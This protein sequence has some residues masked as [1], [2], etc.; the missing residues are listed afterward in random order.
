M[1]TNALTLIMLITSALFA[2]QPEFLECS[3]PACSKEKLRYYEAH[4][5]NN[6]TKDV[7][8][9]IADSIYFRFEVS[10]NGAVSINQQY[11]FA[12]ARNLHHARLRL[13]VLAR[14]LKPTEAGNHY[15]WVLKISIPEKAHR[16]KPHNE[17][18]NLPPVEACSR[19]NKLAREACF[20]YVLDEIIAKIHSEETYDDSATFIFY[21]K[22]ARVDAVEVL[23]RPKE[24]AFTDRATFIID[25][26]ITQVGPN[27]NGWRAD[28]LKLSF[29]N[30]GPDIG[31]DADDDKIAQAPAFKGC[32]DN[33]SPG[34]SLDEC[35]RVNLNQHFA[36]NFRYPEDALRKN[37]QGNVEVEFTITERGKYD[38]IK[39]TERLYRSL[40]F[41]AIRLISILPQVKEPAIGK[42]GSTPIRYSVPITAK[43][44]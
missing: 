43:M 35:F 38:Y 13:D 25:S 7:G 4:T 19:F 6:I 9:T 37:V 27:T 2:Q 29:P 33:A 10:E 16:Y 42:N 20:Y 5:L 34:N 28:D 44:R 17:V 12:S 18:K 22:N 15:E 31:V 40:D 23:R 26:A 41:E 39:V 11:A 30:K 3:T 36:A 8:F 24:I 21:V 32:E 1:K 14:L